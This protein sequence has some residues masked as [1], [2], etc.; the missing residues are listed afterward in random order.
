MKTCSIIAAIVLLFVSTITSKMM[1]E[2]ISLAYVYSI[3][4]IIC[5]FTPL[6]GSVIFFILLYFYNRLFTFYTT[7]CY[8]VF[9]QGTFNTDF[10]LPIRVSHF[11]FLYF[12]ASKR[13]E[14]EQK[15]FR[16]LFT[17]FRETNKIIF[18]SFHIVSLQFFC[19]VSLTFW[20][21][22]FRFVL[23]LFA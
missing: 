17:S 10:F 11:R 22:I 20:L 19:F 1:F 9:L 21:Q 18:A 13:N 14:A 16:F 8:V 6:Q 15:P 2:K 4:I 12:F 23:L 7:F 3:F 5:S